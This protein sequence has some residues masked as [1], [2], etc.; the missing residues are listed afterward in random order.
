MPPT[1]WTWGN[2]AVDGQVLFGEPDGY[3]SRVMVPPRSAR[4]P[5]PYR[6]LPE[7]ID[8]TPI[9]DDTPSCDLAQA[10]ERLELF[11]KQAVVAPALS[12]LWEFF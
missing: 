11:V 9:E 2:R 12:S 10:L 5:N 1:L 6:V 8:V 3:D 7:L 4:L